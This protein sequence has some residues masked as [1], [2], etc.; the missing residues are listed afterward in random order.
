MAVVS[1]ELSPRVHP[2][3]VNPAS[4]R[5]GA[6]LVLVLS[7]FPFFRF[8]EIGGSEV[9]PTAALAATAFIAA[10]GVRR[11]A[12]ICM[13][14]L[15]Y[16]LAAYTAAGLMLVDFTGVGPLRVIASALSAVAPLLV[17][18]AL[19]GRL[20]LL[21]PNVVVVSAVVWCAVGLAQQFAPRLLET[22]GIDA[23]LGALIPRFSTSNLYGATGRGVQM[24]SPEPALAATSIMSMVALLLWWFF[25]RR[26]T[27]AQAL[28]A[29]SMLA[30][31][32]LLNRSAT[33]FANLLLLCI[34]AALWLVF[35]SLLRRPTRA[36]LAA[37][38]IAALVIGIKNVPPD[39]PRPLRLAANVVNA[40]TTPS[41]GFSTAISIDARARFENMQAGYEAMGSNSFFGNG[42]GSS[43]SV[44][45]AA[46]RVNPN[47]AVIVVLAATKPFAYAS[48]V[49]LETGLVGFSS[50]LVSIGLLTRSWLRAGAPSRSKT[51]TA[52]CFITALGCLFFAS[53]ISVSTYW[54]ILLLSVNLENTRASAGGPS[55][56][57]LVAVT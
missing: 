29:G 6:N 46:A 28:T 42:M 53:S 44:L 2:H 32:I 5:V 41:Q 10:F 48:F 45:R 50:L 43:P 30:L 14:P 13:G 37:V 11:R 38:A 21:A 24:L 40:A 33:L 23:V 12:L 7:L 36:F 51:V 27:I 54:L 34:G 15:L 47:A 25:G 52:A 35:G 57:P 22:T 20:D 17:F 3:W 49:S 9:Q 4:E 56:E 31:C 16:V 18:L 39:A 26:I 55:Y 1:V 8:I 19:Y